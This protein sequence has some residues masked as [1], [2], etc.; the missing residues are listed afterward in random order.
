MKIDSKKVEFVA[1]IFIFGV[2]IANAIFYGEKGQDWGP[3]VED[4]L[5]LPRT[6]SLIFTPFRLLGYTTLSYLLWTVLNGIAYIWGSRQFGVSTTLTVFS[7]PF[8]YCLLAGQT[9]GILIAG[10]AI[11]STVKNPKIAGIGIF[12]LSIKP[13]LG[14]F[15]IIYCLYQRRQELR[16]L[17]YIPILIVLISFVLYGFWIPAWIEATAFIRAINHNLNSNFFPY[18]IPLVIIPFF[19]KNLTHVL[20]LQA[21][22]MPYYTIYSYGIIQATKKFSTLTNVVLWVIPTNLFFIWIQDPNIINPILDI[23]SSIG[24]VVIPLLVFFELA[25]LP[26]PLAPP[27]EGEGNLTPF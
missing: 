14:F 26:P 2:V 27:S 6:F 1:V 23:K 11:V 5:Y 8:V 21:L 20:L 10:L 4:P 9:E 25:F 16:Q 19:W 12:L 3:Y 15:P 17:I 13:H 22:I 7:F 24:F 18:L